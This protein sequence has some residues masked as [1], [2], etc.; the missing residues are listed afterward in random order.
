MRGLDQLVVVLP[1]A[2]DA[3][4]R[5]GYVVPLGEPGQPPLPVGAVDA[6]TPRPAGVLFEPV[7]YTVIEIEPLR[8]R[9]EEDEDVRRVRVDDQP[10][11]DAPLAQ[12]GVPLLRLPE[13]T[14]QVGGAVQQQGRCTDVGHAGQR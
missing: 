9:A 2:E 7:Q 12:R 14:G 1:D 3:Q 13:R 5:A 10:G 11:R 6:C 8:G 4:L